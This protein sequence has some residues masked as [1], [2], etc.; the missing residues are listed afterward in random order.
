MKNM[1]RI[2][3]LLLSVVMLFAL[4]AC[5]PKE[6]D[7]DDQQG[8]NDDQQ[9]E[10][11]FPTM[12][13]KLG[14]SGGETSTW[15]I[16]GKHFAE[17]MSEKT[18]G[19]ITVECYGMDQLYGGNQVDGIQGVIDGT[20]DVDMH[21]N[22]IYASFSDK[23]SVV[24]LPFLFNN[25]DEVDAVLDG[26]GGAALAKILE[27]DYGLHFMGMGENGFRHV[28]NN[29][30]AIVTPAD[31][32]NLK[33]RVAGSKVLMEAYK[34]WGADFTTAN[35]SEVYTGLQTGTYDGQENPVPTMDSSA[36]QEVQKYVTYWTGSYDCLMF[37][38]NGNLWN[39]LS[40]DLQAIVTECAADTMEYQRK[41][42]REA[43]EGMLAKWESENGV[44][45]HYLTDEEAAAF[46]ELSAPVYD[47]Y[48]NLLVSDCGMSAE[49][50][51]AFL[52]AFGVEVNL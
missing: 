46:K 45:I 21:S 42:N 22:L 43:D 29:K 27:E 32:K 10:S 47:Y 16:A 17:L 3:A 13:W 19:A 20:T 38:M 50:A 8:N 51:T 35:W 11:G 28:S 40:P 9:G 34:A 25:T 7:N 26:E 44:E 1:K 37:T 4:V 5:G 41:I 24:S 23:F 49:E 36:I 39:S 33:I 12:T 18:N 15:I 52:A 31:M 30:N 2:I 48:A 14:A 6:Q